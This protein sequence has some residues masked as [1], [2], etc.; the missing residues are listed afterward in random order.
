MQQEGLGL[1]AS[2]CSVERPWE[3]DHLYQL[4]TLRLSVSV[5]EMGMMTTFLISL[6]QVNWHTKILEGCL[7]C[8]RLHVSTAIFPPWDHT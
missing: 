2:I 7:A 4:G 6:G 1:A 3:L 5:C 8:S